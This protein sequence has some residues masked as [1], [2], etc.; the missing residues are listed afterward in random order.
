MKV[1]EA[2]RMFSCLHSS[3]V[4]IVHCYALLSIFLHSVLLPEEKIAS[5]K[6]EENE[7]YA[8]MSAT[9]RL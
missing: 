7:P 4:P 8:T 3:F 2:D 9:K 1:S 6:K 5:S